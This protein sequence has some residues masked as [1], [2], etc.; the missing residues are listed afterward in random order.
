MDKCGNAFAKFSKKEKQK[1]K[2][3]AQ[4]S[5]HKKYV[6]RDQLKCFKKIMMMMAK[7]IAMKLKITFT[8]KTFQLKLELKKAEQHLESSSKKH[9]KPD[10]LEQMMLTAL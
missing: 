10:E 1:I 2:I 3:E 7:L 8:T 6:N 5:N 4:A 9:H